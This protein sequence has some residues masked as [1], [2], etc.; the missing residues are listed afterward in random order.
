[1]INAKDIIYKERFKIRAH[2]VDVN[3]NVTIPG[4]LML[5]QEASMVSAARLNVSVWDLE[6]ENLSWVL[7]RKKLV[8]NRLPIL[9]EE[10]EIS[11]YPSAFDRAFASRDY[12]V[13]ELNGELLAYASS[14]WTLLNLSTRK[15]ERIPLN[16]LELTLPEDPIET[17]ERKIDRLIKA[18]IEHQYTITYFDLDWNGH[19]NN[20]NYVRFMLESLPSDKLKSDTFIGIVFH[21]KSECFLKDDLLIQAQIENNGDILHEIT[22]IS[23]GTLVAQGISKWDKKSAGK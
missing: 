1:M 5:M 19:V 17:P 12:L 16:L 22:Q 20:I 3:K 14:T 15:M 18:D 11:T 2:E 6:K 7:L 10:I 21:I 23:S 8:V 4:L 9:G 13:K